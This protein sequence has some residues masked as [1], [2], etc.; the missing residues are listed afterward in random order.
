MKVCIIAIEY[1]EPEY[2]QCRQSI[3]AAAQEYRNNG[4][5][6]DIYYIDRKGVGSM[7][8]AYNRGF[9]KH[10]FSYEFV[11]FVS[12]VVIPVANNYSLNDV[13]WDMVGWVKDNGFS[14]VHPCFNSD[15][16]HMRFNE[17]GLINEAPFLEF[18]APLIRRDVFAEFP[19]DENMPYWGHDLDWG[20]RV[21]QAGHRLAVLNTVELGHTYIRNANQLHPITRKRHALRRVTNASTRAA[22]IKKYGKDWKIVLKL[23]V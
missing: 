1:L 18:T 6:A 16:L 22:L 21:T 2:Q 9:R 19:L 3:E 8:E 14:A 4:F 17:D 5:I 12:N 11:W 13:L 20:Y 7:A 23:H 10:A 15:H